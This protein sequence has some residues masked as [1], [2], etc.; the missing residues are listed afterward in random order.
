MCSPCRC[1]P[2]PSCE[3]LDHGLCRPLSLCHPFPSSSSR[4][5]LLL[6]DLG[7]LFPLWLPPD[8]G[9]CLP[10]PSLSYAVLIAAWF[11]RLIVLDDWEP[12]GF[13]N[14]SR[15][16]LSEATDCISVAPTFSPQEA[17][18]ARTSVSIRFPQHNEL[19]QEN[20]TSAIRFTALGPCGSRLPTRVSEGVIVG[21]TEHG[22]FQEP[23]DR[24]LHPAPPS[25][26][27]LLATVCLCGSALTLP[28]SA[29]CHFSRLRLIP[30]SGIS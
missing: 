2:E 4:E 21:K 6:S 8:L 13:P 22:S 18:D 17:A 12:C 15:S 3:R 27:L 19:S 25:V 20:K 28:P 30:K 16:L 11:C 14:S 29:K 24:C 7:S 1:L 9:A 26:I 23:R 10:A 5:R